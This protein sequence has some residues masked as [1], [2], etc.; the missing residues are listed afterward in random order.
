MI[1]DE[2]PRTECSC[3]ACQI[4]CRTLPGM[5]GVGD[6]ERITDS[7]QQRA[8][9]LFNRKDSREQ[10]ADA[11][12]VASEGAKVGRYNDRGSVDT[13]QIPTIVPA[14]RANG[15]CVFYVNGRCSIH[16]VSP[17]GC[18]HVDPH[19][20]KAE[21]DAVI[22]PALGEILA[23]K[24]ADGPYWRAW[25]HLAAAGLVARPRAERRAAF[26]REFAKVRAETPRQ[27]PPESLDA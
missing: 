16:A 27:S 1:R 17:L 19:M 23:D 25:Q 12:F 7:E 24:Q 14:Q 5:L 15:E 22:H 9:Y 10:F 6:L 3:E 4:G 8:P 21:G 13:F 11:Y 20:S 2:L 18:S 26:E